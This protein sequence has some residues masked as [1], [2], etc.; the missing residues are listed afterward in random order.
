[1]KIRTKAGIAAAV[2][3]ITTG[4]TLSRFI[5]AAVDAPGFPVITGAGMC[6]LAVTGGLFLSDIIYQRI[7]GSE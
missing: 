5:L 1:M 3:M 4:Y 7:L 2:V 6:I